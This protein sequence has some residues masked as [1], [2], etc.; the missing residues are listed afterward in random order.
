MNAGELLAN[1]LSPDQRTREDATQKLERACRENFPAYMHTL[2]SELVNESS[3]PHVRNAAGLALKNALTAKDI[4]RQ[5]DYSNRWLALDPE[6]RNKIKQDALMSLGSPVKQIG[7]VAAQVVQAIAMVE[8]PHNQWPQLIEI[9]LGFVNRENTNLRVATLQAIGFIC[10]TIKPEIL[11]ARSNEILTAVIHGARKEEPSPEVQ[12][13]AI[14]ALSN[15]LEF[16]QDNFERE[17]ERNYIMQVVCEATQSASVPVQVGA[18]ECLVKIMTLYYEKMGFYME[19]ALFGLT[20][21]GMKHSEEAIALQAIDF[22]STV[23]DIEIEIT[24]ENL[25][26]QEFGESPEQ[27]NKYF[28]KI[29]LPEIA[30]VLFELLLRQ[31]ED[32]DEDDWNVSKAASTA[33]ASLAQA[34]NDAVVP[35]SVPFIEANIRSPDWHRREASVMTFGSILDG[36]DPSVLTPLVNQALPILIDM[37]T[38][39]HFAVRDTVAWTLGRICDLLVSTIQPDVHLQPLVTALVNGLQDQPRIIANCAWALQNLAE[40]LSYTEDNQPL[41][42]NPLSPY[43]DGVVQALL[44]TT[45]TA[46]GEGNYRTHAY[47]SIG[48]YITNAPPDQIHVVQNTAVTIL[49][50]LEHMISV[51]NQIIGIDDRNEWND[52]VTH[53]CAALINVIR[54][55][56][57]GIQPLADR[58][59]TLLLQLIQSA[60]K[61]STIVEDAFLVVSAMI[62]ALE[63]NFSPYLNAFLPFLY[64]ALR[65]HEEAELCN[66]AIGIIGDISRSLGEQSA[67]YSAG[68]MSV[69]FENLQS[70]ILN[71]N[72]KISILSCFGD[73]ALAIGPLFEPFLS[74]AMT[75]LR[76]AG[77]I[78]ANPLDQELSEYVTALREGILEAYTGIVAGLKNTD[79]VNLVLPY[80]PDILELIQ[81]SLADTERQEAVVRIC[82]G[83]LG[84]LAETFRNGQIKELLLAE[85]IATE[86]RQKGRMS[87]DTRKN[88]RYARENVKLATA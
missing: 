7:T 26:A 50:R 80:V 76:Q 39:S 12:L 29:A 81:R 11:A 68:F 60:G 43:Y 65:T 6:H 31:D 74:T 52:L 82:Y 40:Q 59:M 64:T 14:H 8:L 73:I 9:L 20:V 35:I 62:N 23:C 28:S 3:P 55:L 22:W 75:V 1:T 44:R 56:S 21:M 57:D 13:A 32:A 2:S 71:R 16:V 36:P 61:T 37:M 58:I 15:S 66:V 84:D 77:T 67:Q 27:E 41:A 51:Q 54:K 19:R 38:D 34:V 17:G 70:D 88:L 30:P 45:E 53:F 87:A 86:L 46:T 83:L 33:L 24:Y 63:Q 78:Q 5:L 72:V 25:E 79:K 49:Q 47:E 10:E 48:A 4:N 69:L 18:F 42:P 85:W